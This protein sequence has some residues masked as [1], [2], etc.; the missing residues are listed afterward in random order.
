MTRE[1]FEK[2]PPIPDTDDLII[3]DETNSFSDNTVRPAQ[4]AA[5]KRC[6]EYLADLKKYRPQEYEEAMKQRQ[7]PQ[8]EVQ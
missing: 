3:I 4:G 1:E 6:E 2:L 7:S 8:G 5:R